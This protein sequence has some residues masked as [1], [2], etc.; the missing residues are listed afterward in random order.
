[1]G[2]IIEL[3]G[4]T[5]LGS[6]LGYAYPEEMRLV[7]HEE[8]FWQTDDQGDA[9]LSRPDINDFLRRFCGGDHVQCV[10]CVGGCFIILERD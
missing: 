1:M 8:G 7:A 9:Y 3:R 10:S 6:Y 5:E 2:K 4:L